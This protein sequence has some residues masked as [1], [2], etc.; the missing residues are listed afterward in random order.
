MKKNRVIE[1]SGLVLIAVLTFALTL[2]T[3]YFQ[4]QITK[5]HILF[6]ELRVLRTSVNLYR[7]I[8]NTNPESLQELALATFHFPGEN[9]KRTYLDYRVRNEGGTNKDR[10]EGDHVGDGHDPFHEIRISR[11]DEIVDQGNTPYH[12]NEGCYGQ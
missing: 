6:H 7:A 12:H 4:R 3:F 5:Q 1:I 10:S 2:V 8:N 9:V 11:P